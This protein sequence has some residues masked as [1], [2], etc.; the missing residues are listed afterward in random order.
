MWHQALQAST[1]ISAVA[2]LTTPPTVRLLN[3]PS[4]R[5]SNITT[6]PWPLIPVIQSLKQHNSCIA[7]TSRWPQRDTSRSYDQ[8]ISKDITRIIDTKFPVGQGR[9]EEPVTDVDAHIA[10]VKFHLQATEEGTSIS[11]Y[12]AREI[13]VG[14]RGMMERYGPAILYGRYIR[15]GV[16]RAS[17]SFFVE[18]EVRR[19]VLTV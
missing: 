8:A 5:S 3:I 16:M 12:E 15:D 17:L 7:I 6:A 1:F 11:L 4:I 14:V 19:G 18:A 10:E 2:A 9:D 13:V